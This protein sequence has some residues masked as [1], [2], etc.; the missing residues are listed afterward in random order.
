[1]LVNRI[2]EAIEYTEFTIMDENTEWVLYEEL[3][4]N[5]QIRQL[6]RYRD[7]LRWW[8]HSHSANIAR[9][10]EAEYNVRCLSD[11]LKR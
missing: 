10:V 9:F 7:W 8:P 5:K 11:T 3:I 1:M 2:S 4:S 6:T